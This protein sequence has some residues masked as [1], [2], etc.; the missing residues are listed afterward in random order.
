MLLLLLMVGTFNLCL[1]LL[2]FSE[3]F[4][5]SRC[6]STISVEDVFIKKECASQKKLPATKS[7][8]NCRNAFRPGKAVQ[9]PIEVCII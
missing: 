9:N 8:L 7:Q 5:V 3:D 4:D 6:L 2:V 1:H